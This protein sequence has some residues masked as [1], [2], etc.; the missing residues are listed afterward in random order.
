MNIQERIAQLLGE[1]KTL[2]VAESCTGGLLSKLIT[3]IPGSSSYLK[4]GA[5]CYSNESKESL[6]GVPKDVMVAH[7]AVSGECAS[8]MA[9]GIRKASGADVGLA[10]TGIAGP[11][12][13]TEE[14]PV[15]LVFIGISTGA[16]TKAVMHNFP[17]NR[18]EVREKAARAALEMLEDLLDKP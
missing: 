11:G 12:G 13:A 2:A 18:I 5:V 14:K 17:G 7:G 9:E 15:G 8:A 1:N 10:I 4:C 6:A 3:D 16:G